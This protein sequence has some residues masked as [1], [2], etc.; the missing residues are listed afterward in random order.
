M[1][2]TIIERVMCDLEVDLSAFAGEAGAFE[3]FAVEMERLDTLSQS[4]IVEIQGERIVV[5]DHGRPF[6]RL[7]AAAFDSYLL[8][9][10]ARHSIA[11]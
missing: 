10:G 9:S 3:R 11:V 4:G 5:T 7:V 2:G 1:R 8:Q 6:A